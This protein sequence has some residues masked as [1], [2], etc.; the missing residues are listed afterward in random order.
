MYVAFGQAREFREKSADMQAVNEAVVDLYRD[1][2]RQP[3]ALLGIFAP[4]DVRNRIVARARRRE[5]ALVGEGVLPRIGKAGARQTLH[6][7]A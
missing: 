6:A 1:A 3:P 4:G 5:V 2:E 7:G